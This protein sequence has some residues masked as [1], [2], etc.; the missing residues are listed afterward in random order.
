MDYG[1]S[2]RVVRSAYG[3]T[4]RKLAARIGISAS[5]LSLIEAGKRDPSLKVLHAI[6]ES[7]AVPMHLLT[8]LASGVSD[9][10]DPA[11]AKGI[12]DAAKA[13]LRLLVSEAQPPLPI[14][15][16]REGR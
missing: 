3:Q 1:R 16:E 8:L 6:A 11:N 10:D 14:G 4:Q 12:A 7:L 13:L 15:T 2:I 9:V 5:H